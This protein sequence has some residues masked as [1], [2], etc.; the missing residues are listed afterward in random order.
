MTPTLN[1]HSRLDAITTHWSRVDDL[2][3][4]ALRYEVA[5]RKYLTALLKNPDA[6][7]EVAHEVLVNILKRGLGEI[8]NNAGRFR[9]YLRSS[10]RHAVFQYWRKQTKSSTTQSELETVICEQPGPSDEIDRTWIMQWRECLLDRTWRTYKH[11]QDTGKIHAG[12]YTILRLAVDNPGL[13]STGLASRAEVELKKTIRPDTYRQLLRRARRRFA[14]ILRDEVAS[15][16]EDPSPEAL[17]DEFVDLGILDYMRDFIH[18]DF[19]DK[20]PRRR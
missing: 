7:Q 15:T 4:F 17:V 12:F 16:L 13:S 19:R 3:Y 11:L 14:E 1:R 8:R 18:P 2:S 20:L 6:V 5:I 9:D 10:L